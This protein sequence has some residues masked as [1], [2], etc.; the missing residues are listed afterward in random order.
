MFWLNIF[1]AG[2]DEPEFL[3]TQLHEFESKDLSLGHCK[4]EF[5]QT[6]AHEFGSRVFKEGQLVVSV[7]SQVQVSGFKVFELPQDACELLQTQVHEERLN[8]LPAGHWVSV[9]GHLH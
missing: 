1:R 9:F 5:E 6:Q 2:H 7:Q 8:D 3:Q 4:L